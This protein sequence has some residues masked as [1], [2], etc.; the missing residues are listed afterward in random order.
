MHIV[1]EILIHIQDSLSKRFISQSL[2][3]RA[4]QATFL[5]MEGHAA[6]QAHCHGDFTLEYLEGMAKVRY[7]LSIVAEV[8]KNEESGHFFLEILNSSGQYCSTESEFDS[9]DQNNSME[10]GALILKLTERK[11]GMPHDKLMFQINKNT[12]P[13]ELKVYISSQ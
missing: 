13:T 9:I 7:S 6:L 2:P 8:L 11:C 10:P 3:E 5:L 4:Q 1:F 12:I